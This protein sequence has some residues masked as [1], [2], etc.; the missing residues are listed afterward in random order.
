[1]KELLPVLR[2]DAYSRIGDGEYEVVLPLSRKR[3]N[4]YASPLCELHG[5]A[6]QIGQHLTQ[7]CRIAKKGGCQPLIY[8]IGEGE[9]LLSRPGRHQAAGGLNALLQVEW[10]AF[11]L[12]LALIDLGEVQNIVDYGQQGIATAVNCLHEIPL[13][14]RQFGLQEQAGK[15]DDCIHGRPYLMAHVGEKLALGPGCSICCLLSC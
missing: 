10:Q 3:S 5:V 12:H 8:G 2:A 11:Q 14:R 1:V 6:E 7:T 4:R 9:S 15:A 13:L